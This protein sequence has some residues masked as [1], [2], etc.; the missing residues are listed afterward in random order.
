VLG[1]GWICRNIAARHPEPR[2]FSGSK[3]SAMVR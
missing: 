1:G 3:E 2:T